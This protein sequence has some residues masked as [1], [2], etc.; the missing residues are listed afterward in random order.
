MILA[1]FFAG[2]FPLCS[3]AASPVQTEIERSALQYFLDN[4]HPKTGLVLDKAPNFNPTPATNRVASM[5]STG[6][7]L[8]VVAN[9]AKRGLVDRALA[10]KQ[11]LKTLEFSRGHVP[12]E[13]GWFLHWVDW[14]SGARAWKS[15]YSP[16]DTA[17]F[18]AGA[19]YAAQVFPHG[20]ISQITRELYRDMDFQF[21]LTNNGAKPNKQT[22]SLSYTPEAGFAPYEWEIYAEQQVLLLLG[23]A[24]PKRPLPVATWKA[25]RRFN[26]VPAMYKRIMGY[27]MPLFVHQYSQVFVDF[28]GFNDGPGDYFE[29]GVRASLVHRAMRSSAKNYKTFAEGFW[30]VSAGEDPEGYKVYDPTHFA[31]TVCIGCALASAM[32][33]PTEVLSDAAKWRSGPHKSKIW[34]RYGFVDSIDLDRKWYSKNVLGIT[35]GPAFMSIANMSEATSIWKDFMKIPEIKTALKRA[36][37]N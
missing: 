18:I 35:V 32:Y 1:L 34:G 27:E 14:E 3:S 29:N 37:G 11:I 10:E 25:W 2:I 9:A 15:E 31:G 19:L 30:G 33:L 26:S 6:F 17:F 13:R 36:Q 20:R 7:G 22:L 28:R 12:R 24:H 16:I 5:A 8:A 23:L 21:F 4:A